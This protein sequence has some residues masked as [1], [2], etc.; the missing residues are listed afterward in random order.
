LT[1]AGVRTELH[2]WEGVWHSFFSDPELPESKAMYAVVARFFDREL[3]NR[4]AAS[5]G[6]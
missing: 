4:A 2:I 5:K 1:D 6:H 3:G